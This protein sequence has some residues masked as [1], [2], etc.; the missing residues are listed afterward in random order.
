MK[1]STA[2]LPLCL[3]PIAIACSINR[4]VVG[5][6]NV[7]EELRDVG[8]FDAIRVDGSVDVFLA[9]GEAAPVRV[10]AEDNLL[11][12][13]ETTVKGTTL[14]IKTTGSYS[15]K[16]GIDLYVTLPTLRS[17]STNGSSDVYGEGTFEADSLTIKT[18]GSS[19][20]ECAVAVGALTLDSN[21]SSDILISGTARTLKIEASGSSDVSA[22]ELV[23]A[24]AQVKT[25]GSSDAQVNAK[26]LDARA[27]GSSDI[28][29]RGS[30]QKLNTSDS[31]SAS[32]GP[33]GT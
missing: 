18:S 4:G 21:G 10:V 23:A 19:D 3:L 16:V 27:T 30:P 28:R 15:T 25:S 20:I 11:P 8:A 9:Q 1:S 5:S 26:I 2:I 12:I 33:E 7:I 6:G 24:E 14:T 31:G 22:Y 13:V 32:I 29:Y 17:I